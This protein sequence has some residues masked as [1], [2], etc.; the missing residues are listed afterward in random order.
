MSKLKFTANQLGLYIGCTVHVQANYLNEVEDLYNPAYD[1]KTDFILSSV[2]ESGFTIMA[3]VKESLYP[4]MKV[5][6]LEEYGLKAKLQLIPAGKM[7]KGATDK[8]IEPFINSYKEDDKKLLSV[9]LISGFAMLGCCME[10]LD[11]FNWIEYDLA[12]LKVLENW[13]YYAEAESLFKSKFEDLDPETAGLIVE[14]CNGYYTELEA[15][16]ILK[17]HGI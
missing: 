16:E 8:H 2:S 3:N 1:T 11:I 17:N 14:V 15:K 9:G 10:S 6:K 13:Y 7:A 5:F 12:G 4:V